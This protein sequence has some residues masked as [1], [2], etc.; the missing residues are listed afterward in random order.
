MPRCSV[1]RLSILLASAVFLL[2]IVSIIEYQNANQM[3]ITNA[4]QDILRKSA[5]KLDDRLT[6]MLLESNLHLKRIISRYKYV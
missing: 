3:A 6:N 4:Q 2:V 5:Q 1:N